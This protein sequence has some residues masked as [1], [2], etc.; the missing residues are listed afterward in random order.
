MKNKI[1]ISAIA[2]AG[3][4]LVTYLIKRSKHTDNYPAVVEP[5]KHHLTEVFA[6]AKDHVRNNFS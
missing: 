2:A 5:K 6:H 1:L 3:A 4:A